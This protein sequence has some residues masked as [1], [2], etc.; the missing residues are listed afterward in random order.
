MKVAFEALRMAAPAFILPFVIVY[1]TDFILIDFDLATAIP[2]FTVTIV[3]IGAYIVATEG[4]ALRSMGL[5][6]RLAFFIVSLLCLVHQDVTVGYYGL[7]LGAAALALHARQAWLSKSAP[8]ERP[9]SFTPSI[10]PRSL[11]EGER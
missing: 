10:E 7:A 6:M 5:P 2:A 4:F 1:H 9:Q 11:A 3:G 8:T